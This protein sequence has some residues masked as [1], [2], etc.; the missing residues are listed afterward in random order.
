M[1]AGHL[2]LESRGRRREEGGGSR[3]ERGRRE[4]EGEEGEE[5]HRPDYQLRAKPACQLLPIEFCTNMFPFS[6][7]PFL[8]SSFQITVYNKEKL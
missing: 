4:G 6:I 1:L 3:E 2:A 7:S 5:S 8:I